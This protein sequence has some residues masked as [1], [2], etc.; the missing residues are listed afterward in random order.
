MPGTRPQLPIRISHVEV[1]EDRGAQVLVCPP[2][3]AR[4]FSAT[5]ESAEQF[6]RESDKTGFI[7]RI[8]C[9]SGYEHA[10]NAW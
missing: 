3:E 8:F 1:V 6:R 5:Q 10:S 9:P 4:R 7:Y 2:E